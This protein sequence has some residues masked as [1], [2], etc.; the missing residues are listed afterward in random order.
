MVGGLIEANCDTQRRVY[1]RLTELGHAAAL[2]PRRRIRTY[3]LP[4]QLDPL[5]DYPETFGRA[6]REIKAIDRRISEIG[7]IPLSASM[8]FQGD[9]ED[10]EL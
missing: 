5:D 2:K 8:T 7:E 10:D 9:E 1:F 6:L 3:D 4:E